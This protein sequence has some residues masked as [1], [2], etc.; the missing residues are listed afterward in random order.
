MAALR[1]L[2]SARRRRPW[3]VAG[4]LALLA[5]LLVWPAIQ[6]YLQSAGI[7]GEF[8][9]HDMSAYRS[10]VSNW[11]AGE[12]LYVRDDDGGFHGSY[13]YPP[14]Y[15]LLFWPFARLGFE[16][17]GIAWNVVSVALLWGGL[18][19]VAAA[20][21]LRLA[22]YE[23]GLLLWAVL[24]F[25]PVILSIRIGQTSVF[26]A[27]LL[28]VALAALVYGERRDDDRLRYLSGAATAVAG[29]LKLVYA[30][31]GAHLLAD[32][33]RLAAAVATGAALLGVGLAVFGVDAHADYLEVL[34]WGKGWGESRAPHLWLPGYYRP[35]YVLGSLVIPAKLVLAGVV[36]ALSWVAAG[37]DADDLTFALGVAAMPLLAPRVYT[38]D[39]AVFLPVVAV[40]LASELSREDGRPLVPV[41]GLWLAAVHA[42]GLYL[43]VDVLPQRVPAGDLLVEYAAWLQPGLWGTL[44]LVGLAARRVAAAAREGRRDRRERDSRKGERRPQGAVSRE[45]RRE[46]E[47]RRERSDRDPRSER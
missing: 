7:A 47:G 43:V 23:R 29:T 39:L 38:L 20:Y 46:C 40:L 10:A 33:R 45:G 19:A 14:V 21:R 26:L 1:Q 4:S 12:S 9:Y 18:Q 42:Y 37:A 30:P 25:Q 8:T 5:F 24:G 16:Q 36:A 27:G 28:A 31:V 35:L 32:R 41:V 22:W 11:Q 44:L 13:L 34:R 2:W 15:V 6:W 3:F 17:S